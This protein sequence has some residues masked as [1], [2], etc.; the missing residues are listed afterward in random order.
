MKM[1]FEKTLDI[2]KLASITG[3]SAKEMRKILTES[4]EIAEVEGLRKEGAVQ[5]GINAQAERDRKNLMEDGQT[6]DRRAMSS[7]GGLKRIQS[8]RRT[9][10]ERAAA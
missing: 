6:F 9:P 4:A 8:G 3:R 1:N 10:T 5:A 7:R 2:G